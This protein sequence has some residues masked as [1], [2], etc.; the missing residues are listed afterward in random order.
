MSDEEKIKNITSPDNINKFNPNFKQT[1]I[2]PNCSTVLEHLDI[3]FKNYFNSDRDVCNSCHTPI[4]LFEELINT[5]DG[6]WKAFGWHY[7]MLGCVGGFEVINVKKGQQ[8][9]I[10]LTDKIKGGR[11]LYTN[12]TPLGEGLFPNEVHGNTPKPHIKRSRFS[13]Y[14]IPV[15]GAG[16]E[17]EVQFLYW[18]APEDIVNDLSSELM[19]DAFEKYY[20]GNYRHM[21]ISARTSIEILQQ[22]FITR[23]FEDCEISKDNLEPFLKD[24]AT[25][26][27]QLKILLPVLAKIMNFPDIDTNIRDGLICLTKNR[28][29]LVHNG[30]LKSGYDD[31]QK[32]KKALL[33]AFFTFKYFKVIH[34]VE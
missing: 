2:C 10:D 20:E 29:S 9:N 16:D 32:L 17:C 7:S 27:S 21:V 4:N 30:T 24:K 13:V 12:Y 3:H 34:K 19:L 1:F 5:L 8:T 18:F 6:A 11:L 23:V 14:P 33:S 25:Y 22:R 31:V 15:E 26:S 28:N